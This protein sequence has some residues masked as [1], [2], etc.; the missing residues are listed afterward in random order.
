[1]SHNLDF[2]DFL[3]SGSSKYPIDVL[4]TAGV[5]MTSPKPI[6]AVVRKMNELLDKMVED[7]FIS[8]ATRQRIEKK[9]I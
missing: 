5:D 6:L 3:K 1:M 8:E 7:G 9:K 2:L 4:K